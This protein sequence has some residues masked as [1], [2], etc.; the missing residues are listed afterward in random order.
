MRF[1][2][3]VI[4]ACMACGK[5][6]AIPDGGIADMDFGVTLDRAR[7]VVAEGASATVG[8]TLQRNMFTDPVVVTVAGLPAG[9]TADPLTLAADTGMLTLHVAAGATQG[10]A[11]L[12]VTAAGGARSHD[13]T[14]SVL[15]AG[16]PGTFDKSFSPSGTLAVS[17]SGIGNAVVIQPDGKIVIAGFVSRTNE[18]ILVARLLPTGAPDPSFSGGVVAFDATTLYDTGSAVA[19][20]P[21]GK[22][23]V[24]GVVSSGGNDSHG[25]V[26]RFNVDGSPD[27]GF[28]TGGHVQ[29]DL[30]AAGAPKFTALNA[31]V[32]QP[33]G[34]IVVA[35]RTEDGVTTTNIDAVVA[36]LAPT[37]ALDNSFGTM[38]HTTV[39]FG[40][41]GDRFLSLALQPDGRIVAVGA[42]VVPV[43]QGTSNIAAFARFNTDGRLDSS[44]SG[45]GFFTIDVGDKVTNGSDFVFGAA[46]R[47]EPDGKIVAAGGASAG[48]GS[49]AC[50]VRLNGNDGSLDNGFGSNG[51]KVVSL[52]SGNVDFV[53]ALAIQ[54]DGKFVIAG[55]TLNG[56]SN[57]DSFVARFGTDALLDL[58][59]AGGFV[60]HDIGDTVDAIDQL[61]GIALD[62]DGRIVATG[63]YFSGPNTLQKVTVARFW[64]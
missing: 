13:A 61:Q 11:A 48:G 20:Q 14:L 28:G 47:I 12:T 35:G 62:A 58:G 6:G 22:I 51:V 49:D 32:V 63:Y 18:D 17:P 38:G 46:V 21:D 9:V 29:L 64:P 26:V 40:P 37:G 44:F 52:G 15:A 45:D 10:D 19:L 56:G 54:P 43:G 7:V 57:T 16:P 42:S 33:D 27:L 25:L 53:N 30:N 5:V 8:I 1:T 24:A 3:L 59:F 31:V 55:G 34:G 41:A 2:P 39:P 50:L 4:L 23:V 60:P 36:R